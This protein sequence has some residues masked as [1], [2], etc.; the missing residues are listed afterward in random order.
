MSDGSL[1][2]L[3]SGAAL[4]VAGVAAWGLLVERNRFTLRELSLEMLPVGQRPIRI[5]HISDMHM[6]PWQKGKQ[7]WVRELASLAPDL[8]V[9]TGDNWGA[10]DGLDGVRAALDDFAGVPGVFVFGSNDYHGPALK[11]PFTY[12][13]GPSRVRTEPKKLDAQSLRHYL[14]TDLGWADLNNSATTLEVAGRSLEF[15]GV[16]DP[17][18]HLD[19]PDAMLDA[20]D[21]I[22]SVELTPSLRVGVAHAPYA[23]TLNLLTDNSADILF[24]GHTHGGQVCVPCYGA[25]VTNCDIPRE[26]VKGLSSWQGSA[27][28]V[29][30]HISAGLGTSIYAPVRFACPPEATLITLLPRKN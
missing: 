19:E 4:V 9:N 11:N 20:L 5:L 16:D 30:L 17:H 22:R 2:K 8:V 29:P 28:P 13:N 21:G 15:F 7:R 24:A 14:T 18:H 12:F 3:L 26:S 1:G 6:A 25:L 10:R 27:G 23:R